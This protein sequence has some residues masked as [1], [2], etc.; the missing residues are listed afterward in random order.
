VVYDVVF[1]DGRPQ[2]EVTWIAFGG[3]RIAALSVQ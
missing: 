2:P 3:D 1:A